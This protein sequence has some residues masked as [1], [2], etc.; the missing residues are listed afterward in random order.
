MNEW[1]NLILAVLVVVI[2]EIANEIII[3]VLK[4]RNATTRLRIRAISLLSCFF[5][6]LIVPLKVVE[7]TFLSNKP[8]V[9]GNSPPYI[10]ATRT[11]LITSSHSGFAWISII[12]V[13]GAVSCFAFMV[14]FS[15]P[16]VTRA[17]QCEPTSDR[18]LLSMVEDV[19]KELHVSVH[20]I[21]IC[22]RKCDAFVYGYPPTFAIGDSLLCLLDDEELRIIIK[23]ELQHVKGRDTLFKPFLTAL[24]IAFLYNPMIWFLYKR[25]VRDREYCCDR[26]ALVSSQ[27]TRAFLSLVLKFYDFTCERPHSLTVHWVG[28]TNRIDAIFYKEKTRKIPV[29]ICLFLTLFSLFV[30]GTQLLQESYM[31]IGSSSQ[32]TNMPVSYSGQL[33]KYFLDDPIPY[34]YWKKISQEKIELPLHESELKKLLQT[35]AFSQGEVIIRIATSPLSRK[36]VFFGRDEIAQTTCQLII[37]VDQDGSRL[38]AYIQKQAPEKRN[39]KHNNGDPVII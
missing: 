20:H 15:N 5:V 30:G 9:M 21:M 12:L 6:F 11:A 8:A 25:M 33:P 10:L 23:H 3:A 16:I 24:C 38:Y 18:R 1:L 29:I 14:L 31:E 39:I 27:D 37:N 22:K 26:A 4:V 7:L 19:S 2:A 17:L 13:L 36:P 35:S 28:A 34:L 32:S